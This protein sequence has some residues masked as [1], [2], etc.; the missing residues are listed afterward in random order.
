VANKK[1]DQKVDHH[2]RVDRDWWRT[3]MSNGPLSLKG[4]TVE[5]ADISEEV[6]ASPD[7]NPDETGFELSR[8]AMI[9]ISPILSGSTSVDAGEPLYRQPG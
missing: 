2:G 7:T 6:T 8:V 5:G 3:W 4:V 1:V 9:A